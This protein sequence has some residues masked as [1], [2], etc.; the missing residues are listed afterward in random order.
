MNLHINARD[1]SIGQAIRIKEFIK[2][3]D[4]GDSVSLLHHEHAG[5]FTLET[6]YGEDTK[7]TVY[8]MDDCGAIRKITIG[9][10]E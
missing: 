4:I 8:E 7:P 1:L 2:N 9:D 3:A 5:W 10:W 6:M